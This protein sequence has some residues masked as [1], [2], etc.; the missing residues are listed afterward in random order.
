MS[1]TNPIL[2]P[3]NE[4]AAILGRCRRSLYDLIAINAIEAVKSGRCTLI[5]YESLKR[6]AASLPPAAIKFDDRARAKANGQ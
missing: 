1:S 5:R 6:Y 2:V 3:L 4:A